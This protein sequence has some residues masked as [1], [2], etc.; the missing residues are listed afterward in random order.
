MIELTYRGID[1]WDRLVFSGNNG[2]YYKTTELVPRE[3]FES[4]S[5]QTKFNLLTSICTTDCFDGEPDYPVWKEGMFMLKEIQ[6]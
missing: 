6:V 4:L 2:R 5:M 3:G 1:G